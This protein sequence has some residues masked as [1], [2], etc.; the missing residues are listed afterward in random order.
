[1]N[2]MLVLSNVP[3]KD[4]VL[5]VKIEVDPP[6][7]GAGQETTLVRRHVL[8]NLQHHDQASRW[9]G[10]FTPCCNGYT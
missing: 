4:E 6:L 2:V 10:H 5:A 3:H 8:L 7:Q 1:M 9:P